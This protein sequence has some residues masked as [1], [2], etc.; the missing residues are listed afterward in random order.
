MHKNKM[1]EYAVNLKLDLQYTLENDEEPSVSKRDVDTLKWLINQ[2]KK[3]EF[4]ESGLIRIG[5]GKA[6]NPQEYAFMTIYEGKQ[7]YEM[8][9]DRKI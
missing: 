2:S 3:A 6:V 5:E 9:P 8:F 7:I 4:Y 1:I